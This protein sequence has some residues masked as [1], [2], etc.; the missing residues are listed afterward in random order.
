MAQNFFDAC[1]REDWSDG[2]QILAGSH[3]TI[4]IKKY[5]GGMEVI[6]LGKPFKAR[7]SIA[8]LLE[9]Q[10]NLRRPV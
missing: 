5:L 2:W 10:P 8:A 6:S 3:S 1:S 7:I 9:L 4:G